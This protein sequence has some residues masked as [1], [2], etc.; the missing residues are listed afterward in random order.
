MTHQPFFYPAALIGLVSIPL[1]LSLI[2]RNR[3]YGI[4]TPKTL[5]D[6]QI[7]HRANQ[8]GGWLFL[9]SGAV[10]LAFAALFPMT[11]NNDPRFTLW[12]AHLT[13]F[14]LP[15]LASLIGT[16]RYIRKL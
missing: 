10:Y 12:L 4:R 2:P 15:L 14:L 6:E 7:W 9:A 8:F 16:M 13:L 5:A 3:L 1:V 11:G